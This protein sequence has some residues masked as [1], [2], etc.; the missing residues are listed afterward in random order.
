MSFTCAEVMRGRTSQ[1]MRAGRPRRAQPRPR[2]FPIPDR[3]RLR[4]SGPADTARR[5]RAHLEVV[6]VPAEAE[7]RRH[8][9]AAGVCQACAKRMPTVCTVRPVFGLQVR[10]V[11]AADAQLAGNRNDA[12]RSV[13]I[14]S[15][16]KCASGHRQASGPQPF[17]QLSDLW[18]RCKARRIPRPLRSRGRPASSASKTAA[19]SCARSRAGMQ[20][21]AG[22]LQMRCSVAASNS[23]ALV[24][25]MCRWTGVPGA[26]R[27]STGTR[28]ETAARL[29]APRQGCRPPSVRRSRPRRAATCRGGGV[30]QGQVFGAQA[31]NGL[32]PVQR[33]AAVVACQRDR[34]FTIRKVRRRWSLAGSSFAG[35]R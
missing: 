19:G 22:F 8:A 35:D 12:L 27:R 5:Q 34:Q 2:R 30:G 9:A 15:S 16:P 26:G 1:S 24:M 13:S 17:G 14:C 23:D 32:G 25:S 6:V 28:T 18:R 3:G 29:P 10:A 33:R 11:D 20:S 21:M 31:E 7:N 4:R